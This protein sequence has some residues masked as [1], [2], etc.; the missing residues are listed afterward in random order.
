MTEERILSGKEVQQMVN[1]GRTSIY[2]KVKNKEFPA[3]LVISATKNGWLLSEVQE[4]I[5][6][7]AKKRDEAA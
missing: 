1:L 4:W 6:E 5:Q 2:L 3:P 7:Q